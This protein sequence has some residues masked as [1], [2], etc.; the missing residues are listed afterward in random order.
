MRHVTAKM[1]RYE[2][3]YTKQALKDW[4]RIRKSEIPNLSARVDFIIRIIRRDP[5]SKIPQFMRLTGEFKGYVLCARKLTPSHL[6]IYQV[7]EDDA[8]IKILSMWDNSN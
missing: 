7:L 6:L 3:H 5:F 1:K 8:A 2:L 4:E